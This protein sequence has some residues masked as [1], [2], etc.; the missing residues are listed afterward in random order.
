L[1]AP[2]G[3]ESHSSPPQTP[4]EAAQHAVPSYT[5]SSTPARQNSPT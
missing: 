5:R 2:P 3:L 1:A 4:Q